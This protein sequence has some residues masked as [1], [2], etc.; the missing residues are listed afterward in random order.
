VLDGLG[1]ARQG[2]TVLLRTSGK[3]AEKS[4]KVIETDAAVIVDGDD[5]AGDENRFAAEPHELGELRALL[6]RA[7]Q[8][9]NSVQQQL[10]E[11]LDSHPEVWAWYGDLARYAE[12]SYIDLVC[13]IDQGVGEA[14]RR[15]LAD[16]KAE[17]A[18]PSPTVM[19]RLLAARVTATWRELNWADL[20][21][22][23]STAADSAT[24]RQLKFLQERRDHAERRHLRA[25]GALTTLQRLLPASAQP[26]SAVIEDSN[27]DG[28]QEGHP[29]SDSESGRLRA[30]GGH[31]SDDDP[32]GSIGSKQVGKRK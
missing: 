22:V 11:T 10:R 3:P 20:V 6:K 5:A 30:V 1:N 31:E 23:R 4:S 32:A 27:Q 19:E 13:G 8:G 9:D 25:T 16:L 21:V 12:E 15:K 7:S 29:D 14:L 18:G 24:M 17:L 2:K 28:S 26:A